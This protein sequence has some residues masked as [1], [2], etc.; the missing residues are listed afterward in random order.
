MWQNPNT[1]S[2]HFA[3]AN[4]GLT[5]G[6]GHGAAIENRRGAGA[7]KR[8][9]AGHAGGRVAARQWAL[10]SMRK[11]LAII[12]AR[13]GGAAAWRNPDDA[14]YSQCTADTKQK[15]R[16]RR[17]WSVNCQPGRMRSRCRKCSKSDHALARFTMSAMCHRRHSAAQLRHQ[18][19]RRRG[20]LSWRAG[21]AQSLG[22]QDNY[23]KPSRLLDCRTQ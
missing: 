11:T 9:P 10:S 21:S 23:T 7:A 17:Q 4:N 22:I 3:F 12:G 15:K 16:K 19:D 18:S 5:V 1:V 14:H 20:S 6:P 8:S 2:P 13:E